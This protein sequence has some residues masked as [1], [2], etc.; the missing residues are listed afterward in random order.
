MKKEI[1]TGVVVASV[2]MAGQVT[3]ADFASFGTGI[4]GGTTF[5][6]AAGSF[7]FSF[8]N[9]FGNPAP[10]KDTQLNQR[11]RPDGRGANI[12]TTQNN[13]GGTVL[14]VNANAPVNLRANLQN[15][16]NIKIEVPQE[17]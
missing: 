15:R 14:V 9:P 3:A 2:L 10:V 11:I 13:L 5:G 16:G 1:L 7:S 17:D 12:P 6:P 4:G 8:N